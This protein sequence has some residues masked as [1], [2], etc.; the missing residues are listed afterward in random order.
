MLSPFYAIRSEGCEAEYNQKWA[1]QATKEFIGSLQNGEDDYFEGV[2]RM[3]LYLYE[4]SI[5]SSGKIYFLDKTPR[6]YNIIPEL[7]RA[8]PNARF[9]FLLRNP[10]ACLNSIIKTWVKNDW[11]NLFYYKFDLLKAPSSIVEGINFLQDKA[12]V[13]KYE[14]LVSSPEREVKSLCE[15]IGVGFEK[16]MIEYGHQNQPHWLLGDSTQVYKHK[17]PVTANITSWSEYLNNSEYW[18]LADDYLQILGK[19]VIDEMGYSY[20]NIK[21]QIDS[22]K[23]S[24]IIKSYTISMRYLIKKEY[25]KRT[26]VE[27]RILKS[28]NRIL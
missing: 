19:S 2:R 22:C 20:D 28:F 26:F 11:H 5:E 21:F 1:Y 17:K 4:K 13:I 12:F 25:S 27:K 24:K 18:R 9:I 3:Y 8:F 14:N 15:Y 6:Y 23:P 7:H 16:E 10:I